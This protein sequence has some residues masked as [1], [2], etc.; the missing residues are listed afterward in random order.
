M[1]SYSIVHPYSIGSIQ[2]L[3]GGGEERGRS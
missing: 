1:P 2:E 3:E